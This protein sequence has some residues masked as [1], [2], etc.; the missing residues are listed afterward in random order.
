MT[1]DYTR[2]SGAISVAQASDRLITPPRTAQL[3]EIPSGSTM[4]GA[5]LRTAHA[6][7][8]H[9]I[10]IS[11]DTIARP[12][13]RYSAITPFNWQKQPPLY[14]QISRAI[15]L[16]ARAQ[17]FGTNPPA[18]TFQIGDAVQL[19]T[20]INELT[21]DAIP[22]D[23]AGFPATVVSVGPDPAHMN[24]IRVQLTAGPSWW[25]RPAH[26][27]LLQRAPVPTELAPGVRVRITNDTTQLARIDAPVE[28]AGLIGTID[29]REDE[30]WAVTLHDEPW[31][32][33]IWWYEANMLEIMP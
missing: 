31:H 30:G 10:A 24:R 18:P 21:L 19:T 3:D 13:V 23:Y 32:G 1:L 26:L 5:A 16:A 6:A 4:I 9:N 7:I 28:T 25:I 14:E 20:S 11:N 29:Q 2:L 33:Q 22:P 27:I 15:A 8:E 12:D 17:A